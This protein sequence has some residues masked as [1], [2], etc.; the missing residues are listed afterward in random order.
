MMIPDM[1]LN[2]YI[3]ANIVLF[4]AAAIWGAVHFLLK[5]TALKAAYAVQLRLIYGMLLTVALAPLAVLGFSLARQNGLI[6]ESF[7][8]NIADF[9]LAQYLDGRIEMA[10][11]RFESLLSLRT[12]FVHEVA[13]PGTLIGALVIVFLAS[14]ISLAV[15]R[16]LRAASSVRGMIRRSYLWRRSGRVE[17]R[18]TDETHIPYSTR[19]LRKHY[20]IVPSALLLHAG[21][22]RI[23]V[24]HELQ[25]I[26]QGDLTWEI[27]LEAVRPLF[28]WNPAFGF[29][30]RGV[31]KLRELACDQAV[32]SRCQIDVRAYCDCLLRVC[33]NSLRRDTSNLVRLPAVAF[34][35]VDAS[36]RG[37]ASAT[38]LRQRVLSMLAGAT[39]RQSNTL[40]ALILIPVISL[41]LFVTISAQR[42]ED[43][44]Q[45]RL[46]LSAI[47]NLER[48]DLRNG[49][50]E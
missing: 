30:K 42:S 17:I 27:L 26:R 22:L 41:T 49:S 18:L 31:D 33:D 13:T 29:W 24:S 1:W 9:A 14:G 38:F 3:D 25:H 36:R 48:L 43:W 12:G 16:G 8:P 40:T 7:T 37:G 10:P 32:L 45:D 28:F 2:V 15:F 21:D 44:S 5:H 6:A 39:V 20:V 34:V 23:A 19:G 4:L 46:M 35:Q 50:T 47:V 11:S